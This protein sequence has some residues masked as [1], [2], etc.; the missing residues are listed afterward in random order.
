[1]KFTLMPSGVLTPIPPINTHVLDEAIDLGMTEL[2]SM[3]ENLGHVTI[4]FSAL[5]MYEVYAIQNV[6]FIE[7]KVREGVLVN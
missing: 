1:M 7:M 3:V 5:S 4:N 2:T 6:A